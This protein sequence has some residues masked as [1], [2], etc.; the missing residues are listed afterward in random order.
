MQL[1]IRKIQKLI[2]FLK[3]KNCLKGKE[4]Q[5]GKKFNVQ[6][7]KKNLET[8]LCSGKEL[9]RQTKN[10]KCLCISKS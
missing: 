3:Y 1:N 9:D 2:E 6:K 10:K 5:Y 4:V 8:E 7:L